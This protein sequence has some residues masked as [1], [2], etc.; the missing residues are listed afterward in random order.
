MYYS[1]TVAPG[2]FVIYSCLLLVSS[3]IS[4]GS[5]VYPP[6]ITRPLSLSPAKLRETKIETKKRNPIDAIGRVKIS[7]EATLFSPPPLLLLFF[8]LRRVK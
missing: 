4:L 2:C 7:R 1:Y 3:L 8:F 6:V 5:T